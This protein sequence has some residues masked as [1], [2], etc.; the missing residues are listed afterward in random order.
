[1]FFPE[2]PV[3]RDAGGSAFSRGAAGGGVGVVDVTALDPLVEA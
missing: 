2:P 1:M 3:T